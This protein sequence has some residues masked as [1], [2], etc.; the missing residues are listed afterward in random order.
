MKLEQLGW[1]SFFIE[2][3]KQYDQEELTVG[4]VILEHKHLYRIM[5][6]YGELLGDLAGRLRFNA[7]GREDF[8]AVAQ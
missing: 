4:R 1:N 3:F 6:E 8:P 2:S 5:T 7:V